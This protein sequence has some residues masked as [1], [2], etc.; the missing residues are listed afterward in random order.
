[1]SDRPE[2]NP[3]TPGADSSSAI[4]NE[5]MLHASEA[6]AEHTFLEPEDGATYEVDKLRNE[7]AALT[8]RFLRL[9]AE[10]DNF[11]KRTAKERLELLQF[12]GENTLKNILPVLD[13]MERAIS[14]NQAV[15]D[16]DPLK[17]GFML[18]HQKL[19]GIIGAQGVKPMADLLGR[20]FDVDRHEA[21][22]KAPAPEPGLKGCVID[23]VEN[24]YTMHDK[25]IRYAK[26]VVGE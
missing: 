2:T 7:N 20:P 14:N 17:Q 12:A 3:E 10:F 15:S 19:L 24:G 18:I 1:M 21:I 25:V 4:S 6:A 16:T 5:E 9:Q 13:D 22:T 11:R 23:V 26:V 8:D